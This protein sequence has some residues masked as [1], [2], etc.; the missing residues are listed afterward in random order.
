MLVV[1][2]KKRIEWE[3]LFKHPINYY[4]DE[5]IKKD[6]EDTLK[7]DGSLQFNMSKFWIKNNK[8]IQHPADINKK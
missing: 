7:N 5:K 6:L 2:F 4:L 3:D 8:V 1:D